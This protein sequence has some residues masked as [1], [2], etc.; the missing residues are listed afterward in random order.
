MGHS[1][2]FQAV[3]SRRRF[4]LR[5]TAAGSGGCCCCRCR[6]CCC[7]PAC[8]PPH[9]EAPPRSPDSPATFETLSLSRRSIT[10]QDA[11]CVSNHGQPPTPSPLTPVEQGIA[12]AATY[13]TVPLR[14][15]RPAYSGKIPPFAPILFSFYITSSRLS[16]IPCPGCGHDRPRRDISFS[17]SSS[18][19]PTSLIP[20]YRR[21][22]FS[23]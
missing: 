20:L 1:L 22:R 13:R 7:W 6:W 17:L 23:T 4:G 3:T 21:L 9:D 15:H 12:N 10:V 18:P 8:A 14:F 2:H 11:G 5:L 19:R 16:I